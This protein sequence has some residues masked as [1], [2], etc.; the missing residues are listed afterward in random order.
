M[1]YRITI[2]QLGSREEDRPFMLCWTSNLQSSPDK[3]HSSS[4]RIA[5]AYVRL[6]ANSEP[7][8]MKRREGVCCE[9]V[10]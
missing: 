3:E 10:R 5:S 6:L 1:L 9:G 8:C 4:L 7:I 2:K